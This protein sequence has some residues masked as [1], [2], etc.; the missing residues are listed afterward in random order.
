MAEVGKVAVASK[1]DVEKNKVFAVL[2]YLGILV[3]VPLLAAKDSP[4]ARFHA[5]Q[6]LVLLISA[7]L[8]GFVMSFTTT[9]LLFSGEFALAGLVYLLWLAP[10]VFAVIGIINAANGEMKKLP[11]IG[12]ITLIK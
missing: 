9:A 2:A 7:I 6:G 5:N 8:L 1:D 11:L 3:L 4:F 12:E 10:L